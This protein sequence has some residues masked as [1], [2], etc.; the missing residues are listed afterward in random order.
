MRLGLCLSNKDR[1]H[2]SGSCSAEH[3]INIEI[4]GPYQQRPGVAADASARAEHVLHAVADAVKD[5]DVVIA[6]A[7]IPQLLHHHLQGAQWLC[8]S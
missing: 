3:F 4:Q 7:N 5:A 8:G 6:A 1:L 2:V